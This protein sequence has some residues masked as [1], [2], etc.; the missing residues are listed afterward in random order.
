MYLRLRARGFACEEAVNALDFDETAAKLIDERLELVANKFRFSVSSRD[1]PLSRSINH[2]SLCKLIARIS[3]RGWNEWIEWAGIRSKAAAMP[4]GQSSLY[5]KAT[6]SRQLVLWS[7]ADLESIKRH[8]DWWGIGG[9]QLLVVHSTK[10][11]EKL[12]SAAKALGF[13]VKDAR[14][15]NPPVQ[16]DAVRT[17][18]DGEFLVDQRVAF[19]IRETDHAIRHAAEFLM[20]IVVSEV[21]AS[22]RHQS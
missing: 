3:D 17:G 7:A 22:L 12:L 5:L 14:K 20:S 2:P 19:L 8:L 10:C 16:V 13:E 1:L 21:M 15:S 6:T 4:S 11:G 18:E 9:E